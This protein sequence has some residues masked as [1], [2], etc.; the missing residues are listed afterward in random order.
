MDLSPKQR[1]P[2]KQTVSI[3]FR[4]RFRK[5]CIHIS[6]DSHNYSQN[7]RQMRFSKHA[8]TYPF[9]SFEEEHPCKGRSP[10]PELG[11]VHRRLGADQGADAGGVTATGAAQC[12]RLPGRGK[13]GEWSGSF[14]VYFLLTTHI[15]AFQCLLASFRTDGCVTWTQYLKRAFTA[16]KIGGASLEC[17]LRNKRTLSPIIEIARE[18]SAC[19][20]FLVIHR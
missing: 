9:S 19:F 17:C 16:P 7:S 2:P 18:P 1:M 14:S 3:G 4:T 11:L 20:G 12:T 6:L 15:S 10:I 5:G 8:N 13:R